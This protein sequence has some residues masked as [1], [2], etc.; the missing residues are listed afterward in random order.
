[1]GVILCKFLTLLWSDTMLFGG[2]LKLKMC[3]KIPEET[4][5]IKENNEV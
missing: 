3:I 4:T 2:R 1:M 5:L